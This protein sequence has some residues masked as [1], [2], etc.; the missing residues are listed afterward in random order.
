MWWHPYAQLLPTVSRGMMYKDVQLGST[1][2]YIQVV[3]LNCSAH[4]SV[5]DNRKNCWKNEICTYVT[6]SNGSL[7]KSKKAT[8]LLPGPV[9]IQ[10]QAWGGVQAQAR[11]RCVQ[12]HAQGGPGLGDVSQHAL[13]HIPP[14]ADSYC[15]GQYAS[16][17]NAFLSHQ[18]M[19]SNIAV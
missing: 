10:A 9:C 12:A 18:I 17:W 2:K 16:Y 14:P 11:G 6:L 8:S 13:R 15:Y 4:P 19:Y 7:T 3:T 1:M 5:P